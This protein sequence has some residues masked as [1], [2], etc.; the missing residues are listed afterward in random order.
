MICSHHVN[1]EISRLFA[2]D[3]VQL[4]QSKS[5]LLCEYY[6]LPLWDTSVNFFLPLRKNHRFKEDEEWG[7]P[8]SNFKIKD[9]QKTKLTS[10]VLK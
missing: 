10:S 5:K 9:L 4:T 1:L 3:F 6:C 7:Q 2:G 8:L